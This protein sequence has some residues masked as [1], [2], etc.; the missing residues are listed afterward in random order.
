MIHPEGVCVNFGWLLKR[1]FWEGDEG[2]VISKAILSGLIL[3]RNSGHAQV[4][5]EQ[6]FFCC[7]VMKIRKIK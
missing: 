6:K 1:K 7:F 5:D 4:L 3:V 2:D